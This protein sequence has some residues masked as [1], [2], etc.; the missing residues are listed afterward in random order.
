MLR[1]N[2]Q[3]HASRISA[4]FGIGPNRHEVLSLLAFR[5]L[6]L[7]RRE[8]HCRRRRFVRI[9]LW[10]SARRHLR[11]MVQEFLFPWRKISVSPRFDLSPPSLGRHGKQSLNHVSHFLPRNRVLL[12][13]R[14]PVLWR[15]SVPGR[16]VADELHRRNVVYARRSPRPRIARILPL[17][18]VTPVSVAAVV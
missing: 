6:N 2:V 16:F 9:L 1:S 14:Q 8:S 7:L 15:V 3:F 4:N 11:Y 12:V 13:V 5:S 18:V 17:R 10:F